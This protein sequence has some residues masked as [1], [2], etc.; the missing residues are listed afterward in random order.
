MKLERESLLERLDEIEL[1]PELIGELNLYLG[2]AIQAKDIALIKPLLHS[3]A[4]PNPKANLD[5]YLYYLLHEYQ[6]EK[7]LNGELILSIFELI[8]QNG[9]NPNRVWG[10]NLRAYDYA[11]AWGVE[12][13]SNLLEQYGADRNLRD[14]I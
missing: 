9:A 14:V 3:G 5:C 11:I 10:N 1:W 8:L 4:N 2:D 7:V 13:I 12:P 6:V